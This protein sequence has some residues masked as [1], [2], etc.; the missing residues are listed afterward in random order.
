[1]LAGAVPVLLADGWILPFSELLDWDSFA[2]RLDEAAAM[3]TTGTAAPRPQA[4]MQ[5]ALEKIATQVRSFETCIHPSIHPSISRSI[6]GSRRRTYLHSLI[7]HCAQTTT[8]NALLLLLLPRYLL[9][10]SCRCAA[11]PATWHCSG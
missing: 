4:T 9:R 8:H 11:A 10:A 3:A 1:M 5:Q 7:H 2:V 6:F